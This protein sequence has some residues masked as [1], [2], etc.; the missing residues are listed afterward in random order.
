M[1]LLNATGAGELQHTKVK[2]S[3]KVETKSDFFGKN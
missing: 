1:E 3:I 2:E